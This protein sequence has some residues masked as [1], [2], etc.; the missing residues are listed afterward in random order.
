MPTIIT[1]HG[2][3]AHLDGEP[4][5]QSA[6]GVDPQWWQNGSPTEADLKKYV[7]GMDDPVRVVRFNWNGDNS[8]L[9][10]RQAGSACWKK[11][12]KTTA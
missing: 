7:E 4:S 11:R 2:T 10:R 5:Q 3:F 12:A 6:P 1:V 8:V 9:A